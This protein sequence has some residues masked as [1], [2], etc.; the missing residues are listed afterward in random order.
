MRLLA[1]L[2][3]AGQLTDTLEIMDGR[4]VWHFN[5][6]FPPVIRVSRR[7]PTLRR[8]D[9]PRFEDLGYRP[10]ERYPWDRTTKYVRP[11]PLWL[12]YYT[13]LG[14]NRSFSRGLGWLYRFG[15]IRLA[16]DEGVMPRL[17][18]IRPWPMRGRAW[19]HRS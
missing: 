11:F 14:A 5:K 13:V 16:C 4:E 12:C 17:R 6:P 1:S 9:A 19:T 8:Q 7:Y 3:D 10:V 15:L 2:R 18:D